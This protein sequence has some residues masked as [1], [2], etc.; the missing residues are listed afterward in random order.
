MGAYIGYRTELDYD[1]RIGKSGKGISVKETGGNGLMR[2]EVVITDEKTAAKFKKPP[3]KFVTFDIKALEDTYTEPLTGA[4]ARDLGDMLKGAGSVLVAG[5]GNRDM[6]ADALGPLTAASVIPGKGRKTAIYAIAP[7]VSGTTG[8]ETQ[9]IIR[10]IV[11]QVRPAAVICVDSLASKKTSRLGKS[12]Q[13]TDT[14]IVPG[15]GVENA[16]EPLDA[17]ALGVPVLAIGVP[18]VVYASTIVGEALAGQDGA[19]IA[20]TS[21]AAK[22]LGDLVVTPREID[23]M[24]RLCAGIVSS[25]INIF[26]GSV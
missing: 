14:G 5:L 13:I 8:L 1:R 11:S 21:R 3:G 19:E 6:T 9:D 10:G 2:T 12:F 24:V 20:G 4:I 17:R 25:A 26:A 23:V 18:M 7:G 15:G 22:A 16:R